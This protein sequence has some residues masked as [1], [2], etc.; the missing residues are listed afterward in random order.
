MKKVK[1]NPRYVAYAMAHGRC[2]EKMLEYDETVWVGGIMT[3]FKL[4]ISE[5]KWLFY[6]AH[7]EYFLD[8]YN[9]NNQEEW[10]KWLIGVAGE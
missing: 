7:P 10:S 6:K 4:W 2:V 9:I 5:Q 8:R 3:G 1:Y